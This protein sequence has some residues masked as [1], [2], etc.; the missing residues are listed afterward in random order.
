MDLPATLDLDD[1]LFDAARCIGNQLCETAVLNDGGRYANWLGRRDIVDDPITAR[2]SVRTGA[3]G[4]ELYGGSAGVALFLTALYAATREARFAAVAA[5][6]LRR[7]VRYLRVTTLPLHPHSFFAGHAGVLCALR[8]LAAVAPFETL[9]EERAWLVERAAAA[10]PPVA[11]D[12]IAGAAGGILALLDCGEEPG[13]LEQAR[14]CGDRLCDAALWQDGACAWRIEAASDGKVSPPMAGLAHGGA[15]MALALLA[16]YRAVGEPRYL[17][18]ARG[19][20]AFTDSLFSDA[21]GAWVDSRAPHQTGKGSA[22]GKFQTGWCH[23]AAGILLARRFAAEIDTAYAEEHSRY[24]GAGAKAAAGAMN[25]G[26]QSHHGDAS[27]CHGLLGHNEALSVYARWIGDTVLE[28]DC[29]EI[30]V[31]LAARHPA[32]TDWPS[33]VNAG[34]PN[35]S[36]MIGAAGIGHHMLRLARPALSPSVLTLFLK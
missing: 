34:G 9:A 23:G 7:S 5:A 15:G 1:T 19:A 21:D 18:T 33:G 24:A 30:A 36:L 11:L 29:R 10:D 3:L 32:I 25:A 26:V 20:L 6:A 8:R 31:A 14:R 27:L 2:F 4:P 28:A 16:L 35:P 12:I 22:Q 17:E 13:L